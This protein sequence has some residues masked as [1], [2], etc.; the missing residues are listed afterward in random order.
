ML[1]II[2]KGIIDKYKDKERV[3]DILIFS[4]LSLH[5]PSVARFTEVKLKIKQ[6][7][8]TCVIWLLPGVVF[9]RARLY[10]AYVGLFYHGIASLHCKNYWTLNTGQRIV[11][12]M[13]CFSI[14]AS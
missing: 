14:L 4:V 3:S 2:I 9:D 8:S 1:V 13:N 11:V 10:I 5:R 7:R 6:S 12:V